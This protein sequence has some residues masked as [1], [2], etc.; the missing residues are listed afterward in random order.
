MRGELRRELVR[1]D[2]LAGL[3]GGRDL[4]LDPSPADT[5]VAV[6]FSALREREVAPAHHRHGAAVAVAPDGHS[7]GGSPTA[8][9]R[10]DRLGRY[11]DPG[12]GLATRLQ[13]GL[14]NLTS[15][16]LA[17]GGPSQ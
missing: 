14:S 4:D 2:D 3:P 15:P 6:R 1:H 8:V 7:D 12:G 5:P 16:K 10:V 11:L 9:H 13:L 17:I